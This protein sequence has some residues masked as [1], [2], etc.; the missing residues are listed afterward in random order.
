MTSTLS[1]I[2]MHLLIQVGWTVFH[3]AARF[4]HKNLLD[5]LLLRSLCCTCSGSTIDIDDNSG[6]TPLWLADKSGHVD[7]VDV[8]LV[9]GADPDHRRCMQFSLVS[10][11]TNIKNFVSHCR[12]ESSGSPLDIARSEG[13]NNIVSMMT[14]ALKC[15]WEKF[16]SKNRD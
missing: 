1:L 12:S 7:C 13:H 11:I 14:E 15:N 10:N 5:R 8:L 4:N 16:S 6:C 2:V 9:H 3:Y